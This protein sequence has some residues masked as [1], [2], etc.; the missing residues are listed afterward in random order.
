MRFYVG[1]AV[2]SGMSSAQNAG[3]ISSNV[4]YFAASSFGESP[5]EFAD[6]ASGSMLIGPASGRVHPFRVTDA[7]LWALSCA[8]PSLLPSAQTT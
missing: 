4:R 8:A 6:E 2:V 3:A 7:A 1:W 5:I